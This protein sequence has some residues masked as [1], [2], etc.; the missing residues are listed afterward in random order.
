MTAR[1]DTLDTMVGS[2]SRLLPTLRTLSPAA[3][4]LAKLTTWWRGRRSTL[5]MSDEWMKEYRW[6]S[7]DRQ[8]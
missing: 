4:T 1:V 7:R 5:V 6:S 2:S 3:T 8:V